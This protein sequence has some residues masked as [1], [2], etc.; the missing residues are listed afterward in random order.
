MKV[1]KVF[2]ALVAMTAVLCSVAIADELTIVAGDGKVWTVDEFDLMG[3]GV[4]SFYD[5]GK[6][7]YDAAGNRSNG[8]I[9][10]AFGDGT[11]AVTK[12]NTLGTIITSGTIGSGA[13]VTD[14]AIRP[15]G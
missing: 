11:A 10:I 12:Y 6:A 8:D 3:T 15:N 4:V 7:I 13:A 9:V 1:K 14:V 2:V 5:H